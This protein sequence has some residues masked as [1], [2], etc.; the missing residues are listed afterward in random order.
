[1]IL[2]RGR[3]EVVAEFTISRRMPKHSVL[4]ANYLLICVVL[5]PQC[6]GTRR[7]SD[8]RAHSEAV[9]ANGHDKPRSD[10]DLIW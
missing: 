7:Y 2:S 5:Y 1:M 9:P 8:S 6:H 10:I 3:S 4:P